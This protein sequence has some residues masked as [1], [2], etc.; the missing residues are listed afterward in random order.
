MGTFKEQ[1]NGMPFP[2]QLEKSR[3]GGN[4]SDPTVRLSMG[5][6][7]DDLQKRS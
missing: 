2:S 1:K 4:V 5:G 6:G 3:G 7:P